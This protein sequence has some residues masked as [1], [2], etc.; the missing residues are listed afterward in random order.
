MDF[1]ITILHLNHTYNSS[2]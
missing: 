2:H 1:P